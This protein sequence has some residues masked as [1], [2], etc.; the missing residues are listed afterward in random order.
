[1]HSRSRHA[2]GAVV[3]VIDP[4]DAFPWPETAPPPYPPPMII[5]LNTSMDATLGIPGV[6]SL[7]FGALPDAPPKPAKNCSLI[8]PP[9]PPAAAFAIIAA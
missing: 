4:G 6:P 5:F 1:M 9:L 8:A 3:G 7:E 2:P